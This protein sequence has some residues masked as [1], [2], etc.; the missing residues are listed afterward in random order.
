MEQSAFKAWQERADNELSQS[1]IKPDE[2]HSAPAH[3]FDARLFTPDGSLT[4]VRADDR[5]MFKPNMF[6]ALEGN[7]A[8]GAD[9][10]AG[11]SGDTASSSMTAMLPPPSGAWLPGFIPATAQRP[12]GS[13]RAASLLPGSMEREPPVSRCKLPP[14]AC[15]PPHCR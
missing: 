11:G 14:L 3:G 2:H 12:G 1:E 7:D 9:F 6:I 13:R 15:Q 10:P 4:L 8:T 5:A